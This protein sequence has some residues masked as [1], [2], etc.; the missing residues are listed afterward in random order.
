VLRLS[1]D[2][3]RQAGLNVRLGSL[4]PEINRAERR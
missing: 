3:Q 1:S 2:L 4:N